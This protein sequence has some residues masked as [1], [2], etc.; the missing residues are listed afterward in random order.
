MTDDNLNHADA[1]PP[2]P[3][4]SRPMFAFVESAAFRKW[5]LPGLAAVCVLLFVVEL[6]L[7]AKLHSDTAKLPGKYAL[8]GLVS[9]CLAV[10]AAWAVSFLRR[11]PDYYSDARDSLPDAD[12]AVADWRAEER[13]R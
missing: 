4:A 9:V 7:P 11:G 3:A 5:A 6:V 2:S 12:D 1:R 13:G 10:A 8:V